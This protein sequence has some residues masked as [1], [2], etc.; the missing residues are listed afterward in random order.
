MRWL[1][2]NFFS[3]TP[4][5]KTRRAPKLFHQRVVVIVGLQEVLRDRQ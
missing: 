3:A 1:S 4:N 5:Q 2:L